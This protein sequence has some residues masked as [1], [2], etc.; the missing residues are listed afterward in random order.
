M[1]AVTLTPAQQEAL[2]AW[3]SAEAAAVEARKVIAREQEARKA[4]IVALA[5]L[6]G[7]DEG[8]AYA[9]VGDGWKIKRTQ[10]YSRKI[11][12]SVVE[13]LREPLKQ[14]HVKLDSLIDWKP[15]LVTKQYRELTAEAK[16]IFD[17]CLTTTP[18]MPT[19]E[20]VPPKV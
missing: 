19:I 14:Y 20:I 1:L 11:D 9:D 8:T 7:T 6:L 13:S 17:S 2:A 10:S 12:V 16:A 18:N 15:S 5:P 3:H 4:A